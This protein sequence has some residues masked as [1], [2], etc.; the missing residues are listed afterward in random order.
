MSSAVVL[1]LS[2]RKKVFRAT[3]SNFLKFYHERAL[4]S[5]LIAESETRAAEK[6]SFAVLIKFMGHSLDQKELVVINCADT[7]IALK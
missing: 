1:Y 5:Q 7:N 3:F 4:F 2:V 6:N